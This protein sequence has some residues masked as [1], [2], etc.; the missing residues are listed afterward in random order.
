MQ[1]FNKHFTMHRY[2]PWLVILLAASFLFY[3]YILQ[4]SP[5]IMTNELMREFNLAGV[6][7]GNLA[8]SFFYS[9]LIAQ[10][11]VGVL[12]DKYSPRLL[13]TMALLLC[14]IAAYSFSKAQHLMIAAWS[15]SLMGIG[16]AFATV[17][18]M[19]MTS[20][21]FKPKQFA[22]VGGLLASAAMLGAIAGQLP[23][24]LII[25]A[26]GWRNSL[27]LCAALGIILAILFYLIVRDK[28]PAQDEKQNAL[29]ALPTHSEFSL[30][31][32]W[33]VLTNKQNW[34]ITLYSGL[35]F[36]PID[37]FAGLWCIPFLKEAYHFTYTQAAFFVSFI[38]FGLA[39]GSP[40][41]GLLSDHLGRRRQVM[42]GSGC[43]ALATI[44]V[45]IHFIHLPLWLLGGCLFLFGFSTGAFMLGFA[46]GRELNKITVAATVIALINTGDVIFSA[47]TEPLV[48]KLLDIG[49]SG[50]IVENIHYFSLLDYRRA[51]SLLPVYILLSIIVTVFLR[52]S[53]Y[54]S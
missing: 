31:D 22:F 18:Y 34:L 9:F 29:S 11:F 33:S 48:G 20:L 1:L 28:S 14:A 42:C 21:W 19:K 47:L 39:L 6:G 32:V 45:I 3:K 41:L 12:L 25:N 26:L 35:A 36:S 44:T 53:K 27:E 51:L 24:S 52:E 7:L 37:A 40:L 30:Q 50:K 13:T 43:I 17:S 4:V 10:L 38:F 15:R 23:L 2:Y 49:W 16:A 5:S 8:A 46:L 54:A